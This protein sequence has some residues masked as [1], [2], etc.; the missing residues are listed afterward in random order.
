[1]HDDDEYPEFTDPREIPLDLRLDMAGILPGNEWPDDVL[2][3]APDMI[4]EWISEFIIDDDPAGAAV[5]AAGKAQIARLVPGM[6]DADRILV[7]FG[8]VAAQ[9]WLYVTISQLCN[10]MYEGTVPPVLE[11]VLAAAE[12]RTTLNV[13]MLAE[14]DDDVDM[15]A[16]EDML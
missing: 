4:G 2:L 15:Q 9:A 11:T 13:S 7:A 10:D 6:D 14:C 8:M 16:F 12:M 5:L 3:T 1:M